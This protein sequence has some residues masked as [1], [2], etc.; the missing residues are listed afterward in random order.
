MHYHAPATLR[1]AVIIALALSPAAAYVSGQQTQPATQPSAVWTTQPV[2]GVVW[3]H[4][5]PQPEP[6]PLLKDWSRPGLSDDDRDAIVRHAIEQPFDIMGPQLFEAM[7]S[8]RPLFAS[9]TGPPDPTRP[10]RDPKAAGPAHQAYLMAW[11]V[12]GQRLSPRDQPDASRVVL[13]LLER[14]TR[15]DARLRLIGEMEIRAW[16]PDAERVLA[17]LANDPEAALTVRT[18]AARTLLRKTPINTHLAT[19]LQVIALHSQ[20]PSDYLRSRAFNDV[21]NQGN[22][23]FKLSPANKRAT[24]RLGFKTLAALQEDDYERGYHL[25]RQLGFII[26]RKNGFAPD[27]DDPEYRGERGLKP[28]FF[29][30]TTRNALR[31]YAEHRDTFA[32]DEK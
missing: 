12:W 20:T 27:Q 32:P 6:S 13:A 16:H 30:D 23:L 5:P 1:R 18:A 3:P 8:Y 19:A 31:Y 7:L 10:W 4:D 24:L 28:G 25:A 2:D 9:C 15:Q 17:A 26:K 21:F 14:E 22:R 11:H 29:A